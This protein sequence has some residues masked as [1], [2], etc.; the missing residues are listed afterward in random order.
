MNQHY[1]S[2]ILAVFFAVVLIIL[3]VI[4]QSITYRKILEKARRFSIK[5]HN[6][7]QINKRF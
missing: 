7:F 2:F 3:L 6:R 5:G 1:F 4:Q